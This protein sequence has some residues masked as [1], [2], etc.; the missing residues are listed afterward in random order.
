[1]LGADILADSVTGGS[2]FVVGGASI[3]FLVDVSDVLVMISST[4]FFMETS[5]SLNLFSTA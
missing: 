5:I 3:A 2:V 1:M 4:I